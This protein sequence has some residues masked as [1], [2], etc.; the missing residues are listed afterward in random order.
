M[1]YMLSPR[2][3][4]PLVLALGVV[5]LLACG[6]RGAALG[7]GLLIPPLAVLGLGRGC[8]VRS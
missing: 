3:W 5:A 4:V 6:L 2:I 7:L 1:Q 8:R